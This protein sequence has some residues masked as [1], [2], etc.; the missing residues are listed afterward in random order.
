M[1]M[2]P[3]VLSGLISLMLALFMALAIV[4]RRRL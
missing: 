3:T 4:R 2:T 1:T